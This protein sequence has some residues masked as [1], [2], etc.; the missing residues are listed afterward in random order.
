M[1]GLTVA[2]MYLSNICIAVPESWGIIGITTNSK[3]ALNGSNF[4]LFC[5]VRGI[6]GMRLTA[7]MEWVDPDGA[8]VMNTGKRTVT[9]VK[10]RGTMSTFSLSFDPILTSDGGMY[11][12]RAAIT[13]PWM[14]RQPR[15]LTTTYDI[16]ITSKPK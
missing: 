16:P 6:F 5:T 2:Y 8:V 14:Q 9:E 3:K 7:A 12:C 10:T 11:T 15:Q 13:V 4:T 1:K